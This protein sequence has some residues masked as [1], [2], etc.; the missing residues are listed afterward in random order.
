[1]LGNPLIGPN[2]SAAQVVETP[3][4][5]VAVGRRKLE[6]RPG[7]VNYFAGPQR[8]EHASLEKIVLRP[9]P[10][11]GHLGRPTARPFVFEK[12]LQHAD[13]RVERRALTLWGLTVPPTILQ[14]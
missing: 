6:A 5:V 10:C 14:L 12:S 1:R 9:G 11:L 7:S 2:T 13:R 8:P 3:Q 4:H